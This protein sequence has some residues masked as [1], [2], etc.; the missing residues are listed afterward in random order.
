MTRPADTSEANACE[1]HCNDG[2]TSPGEPD[3]PPVTLTALPVTTV[4]LAQLAAADG[5]ARTPL[6]PL[7]GAPPPTLR[8]CR[9]LI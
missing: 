1:V 7:P 9:L 3:L 5:I 4:A 8:F 2:V 6:A